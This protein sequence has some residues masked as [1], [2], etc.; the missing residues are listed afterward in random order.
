MVDFLV[1]SQGVSLRLSIFCLPRGPRDIDTAIKLAATLETGNSVIATLDRFQAR[2]VQLP[3][4]TFDHLRIVHL[5][6]LTIQASIKLSKRL[7]SDLIDSC[8]P[9]SR[10]S[11]LVQSSLLG[12]VFPLTALRTLLYCPHLYCSYSHIFLLLPP[13][14]PP[15]LLL[16]SA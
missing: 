11:D 10:S 6:D 16:R 4:A 7:R 8:F 15:L 13:E 14:I 5:I 9:L 12:S 2:T 1:R 3:D